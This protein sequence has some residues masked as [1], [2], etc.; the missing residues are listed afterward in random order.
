MRGKNNLI[1]IQFQ[2][3]K[4]FEIGDYID[5]KKIIKR[6]QCLTAAFFLVF[7]DQQLF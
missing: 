6:H 7:K 2:N 1:L 5:R 4:L 3:L